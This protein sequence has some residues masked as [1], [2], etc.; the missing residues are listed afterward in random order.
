MASGAMWDRMVSQC[1]IVS[2]TAEA[3][4]SRAD[5]LVRSRPPGRLFAGRGD[6]IPGQRRGMRVSRADRESALFC[7]VT[8]LSK[9]MRR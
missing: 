1:H 4:H 5:P 2:A 3:A 9:T 8:V 7:V 6:S